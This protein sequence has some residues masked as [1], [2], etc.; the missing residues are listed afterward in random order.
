MNT[1]ITTHHEQTQTD[2]N[3]CVVCTN[4][5]TFENIVNLECSHQFCKDCMWRWTKSNN[6]CPFCRVNILSN[7]EEFQI[8]RELLTHRSQIVQQVEADV[9]R[10]RRLQSNLSQ[11]DAIFKERTRRL[12]LKIFRLK[13]KLMVL[14]RLEIKNLR[15]R[16]KKIKLKTHLT[17]KEL[18]FKA[19]NIFSQTFNYCFDGDHDDGDYGYHHSVDSDDKYYNNEEHDY[20]DHDDGD[21]GWFS[22]Y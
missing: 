4:P 11:L 20:G 3:N 22:H 13:E 16:I 1:K 10:F 15:D 17:S 12:Q 5:L 2:T 8:L 6:S 18:I 7:T 19:K 9:V 21:Y 14:K